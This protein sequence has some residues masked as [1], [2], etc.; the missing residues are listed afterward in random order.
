MS[1]SG[2]AYGKPLKGVTS[3]NNNDL[4]PLEITLTSLASGGSIPFSSVNITGGTIDGVVIGDQTPGPGLFTTLSVGNANGIGYDA[5][6]YGDIVGDKT[7]WESGIGLWNIQADLSVRDIST[8]GNIRI[9]Q[10]TIT[11]TNSNGNLILD[12]NGLGI[13][14]VNAPLQ[15]YTPQG[16]ITLET[17]DG[18]FSLNTTES[19]LMNSKDKTICMEAQDNHICLKTG[20][21]KQIRT[22]SNI[23]T[24]LIP[25]ITTTSSHLLEVGDSIFLSN[26]D[27][28][29]IISGEY[30][31]KTVVSDTRFTIDKDPAITTEGTIGNF[32]RI[33]DINLHSSDN[34]NI[35]QDSKL[36]FGNDN[37][38][39]YGNETD[40]I[41][42][43][44]SLKLQAEASIDVPI[45]IP[46]TFADDPL[47]NIQSD[48]T[49]LSIGTGTGKLI[50]NGDVEIN[51]ARTELYSSVL[52]ITDP[53]ITLGGKDD[54]LIDDNK[55]RGVEYR[56]NDGTGPK[57][58]FFGM[59]DS[60]ECF[61]F[62]PDA[63]NTSE[64]FSGA[65]GNACFSNLTLQGSITSVQEI[66]SGIVN[67]CDIRCDGTMNITG[68]TGID[69]NSPSVNLNEGSFLLFGTTGSKI[70]QQNNPECNLVI[71]S[72]CAILLTPTTDVVLP[73]NTGLLLD[74]LNGTQK[75]E[76]NINELT[77][78][79]NSYT[80][81]ENSTG[82]LKVTEGL[83]IILNNAET[84]TITGNVSGSIDITSQTS[85]NLEPSNGPVTI[86][87][88]V[89]LEMGSPSETIIGNPGSISISSSQSISLA[90]Q[91]T[92]VNSP[93]LDVQS[94]S[95]T[96][97]DPILTLGS[98]TDTV[99]DKGIEYIIDDKQGFFGLDTS[100]GSFTFIP[101][102]T[103]INEV[104]TGTP[105]SVIFGDT[106]ITSLDVN[107]GEISE[108]TTISG[109]GD[110]NI[111]SMG[112]IN[113]NT[114]DNVNIPV[115]TKLTFDGQD[116]YIESDGTDLCINVASPGI[117]C[118]NNSSVINGDLQV[119]G[120]I[121]SSS[122][123]SIAYT[124]EY[125]TVQGGN[126]AII[127]G[128]T[129][130]SFIT[131]TGSGAGLAVMPTGGTD[132][133]IKY[134]QVVDLD[135]GTT[136]EIT[137]LTNRFTDPC[138]GISSSQKAIFNT[139]GQGIALIWSSIK[140][141]Y[142]IINGGGNIV[143]A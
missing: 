60:G 113:L 56:W 24:G 46:I 92:I 104:I 109:Q 31:V 84:S 83:P 89:S 116:S 129:N 59:D 17:L 66:T 50:I 119:N 98:I 9:F 88:G 29:P 138:A 20:T 120:Q 11:T 90:T 106:S 95:V 55:D 118:L 10:N 115:N 75:I 45:D 52:T 5:C 8:L 47:K 19:I 51:G 135:P 32:I 37:I 99:Q 63:T 78:T 61:T 54:I 107:G 48:G 49:N 38:S 141:K 81:F 87:Q 137:F 1:K 22:I 70:H 53:V 76:S 97:K 39:I 72:E 96:I 133:L 73:V 143:L 94:T 110:I 40:L 112:D 131:V 67:T 124:T 21:N 26:T 132:G 91:E 6:F 77:I 101:D 58:G 44:S 126:I 79:S 28:I 43:G 68:T 86:P 128:A 15:Q 105:G 102:S 62:I 85:I 34:V 64:V 123:L 121:T 7:C 33:T 130:I 82:G 42:S 23:S 103:N 65:V 13:V 27:S 139:S 80:I 74:G 41:L 71:E 36:T 125:I 30:I 127:S 14:N 4:L 117:F 108:V 114:T 18:F 3:L 111:S 12:A 57:L 136:F 134:V 140:G 69:L 2:S 16:D 142:F 122:P 93:I 100:S 25:I 35:L